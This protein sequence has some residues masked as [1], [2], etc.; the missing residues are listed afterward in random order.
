MR[1]F[2]IN[3]VCDHFQQLPSQERKPIARADLLSGPWLNATRCLELADDRLPAAVLGKLARQAESAVDLSTSR[4]PPAQID[5]AAWKGLLDK[6]ADE[7]RRSG[8]YL[9]L[10]RP[11]LDNPSEFPNL[12][13]LLLGNPYAP[14]S[15]RL[16]LALSELD[17]IPDGELQQLFSLREERQKTNRLQIS[18]LLPTVA[19]DV[20]KGL[21]SLSSR[22]RLPKVDLPFSDIQRRLETL[23]LELFDPLLS[24][25]YYEVPSY[26][27][28]SHAIFVNDDLPP[29][30]YPVILRHELLHAA[31][32][33]A[34]VISRTTAASPSDEKVL[35]PLSQSFCWERYGVVAW[36]GKP[37]SFQWLNEGVTEFLN[38][39]LRSGANEHVP[40]TPG[41]QVLADMVRRL[42]QRVDIS[43]LLRVY[44]SDAP[45]DD[46][47]LIADKQC[48]EKSLA[49][50]SGGSFLR[51]LDELWC[52]THSSRKLCDLFNQRYSSRGVIPTV[53]SMLGPLWQLP[54]WF[55][56]RP[57]K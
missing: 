1:E 46:A 45:L 12:A 20:A 5:V 44:F 18:A 13:T 28:F 6:R 3:K 47:K 23:K 50:V 17:R 14:I 22:L 2:L 49:R 15:E 54:S 35:D 30:D 29:Q 39:T 33:L 21:E 41:P 36:D 37:E 4:L 38:Q 40:S 56:S 42:S 53:Y 48:F 26:S 7:A 34:P 9:A 24:N 57:M 55:S 52:S 51:Q 25:R 19:G 32:G 27:C 11:A 10:L 43:P 16:R 31:A 8:S